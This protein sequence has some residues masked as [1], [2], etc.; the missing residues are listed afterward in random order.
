MPK[1]RILPLIAL[2]TVAVC[3]W[4]PA[5]AIQPASA[6]TVCNSS[7]GKSGSINFSSKIRT[8]SVVLCG[9]WKK[10]TKPSPVTPPKKVV[11]KPVTPGVGSSIVYTHSV[12]AAP[13]RPKIGALAG[14]Q[15]E[16]ASIVVLRSISQPVI[17]YRYLLG[18]P[19]QIRF[20]PVSYFW[21]ISD[22]ATSRLKNLRHRASKVGIMT[23]NLKVNFLV[24]F[25]P[26]SGGAW[27][28]FNQTVSMSAAPVRLR[29]GQSVS[30]QTSL[31]Y[32]LFNCFERPMGPGC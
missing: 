10:V 4:I 22:G 8:S 13:S 7:A 20:T 19:T 11:A 18:L 27:R 2:A 31:R 24:S 14:S 1:S 5:S 26:P 28:P 25:R 23:A 17:R 15:I 6:A 30:S 29:V 3:F 21:R 16:L 12:V 32:V 9:D